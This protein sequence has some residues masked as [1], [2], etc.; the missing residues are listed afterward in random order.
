MTLQAIAFADL[1]TATGGANGTAFNSLGVLAAQAAPALDYDPVSLAVR[2]LLVRRAETNLLGFSD[3]FDQFGGNVAPN[4]TSVVANVGTAPDGTATADRLVPS[5]GSGSHTRFRSVASLTSGLVY[6]ASAVAKKES[7]YEGFFV[8]LVGTAFPAQPSVSVNLSTGALGAAINGASALIEPWGDGWYRLHCTATAG[9]TGSGTWRAEVRPLTGTATP[10]AGD[11]TSGALVW[12]TQFNAG[13][14]TGHIPCP[15]ASAV[16]RTADV[17][18]IG[19][20]RFA[21]FF[22]Q[23]EGTLFVQFRPMLLPPAAAPQPVISAG[24]GTLNNRVEVQHR[25]TGLGRAAVVTGGVSQADY[26]GAAITLNVSN[27]VALSFRDNDVGFS[28]NGGATVT[29]ATATIA[30][31]MT[32][33]GFGVNQTSSL[34]LDGWLQDVVFIPKATPAAELPALAARIAAWR[35]SNYRVW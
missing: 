27:T 9:A 5:T 29:D 6:T 13:G 16:A 7:S 25:D 4:D 18:T 28:V 35:A 10:Y 33:L 23:G 22:R 3:Q 24:D 15:T 32:S 20:T 12:G 17:V 31:V 11:G 26:S 8:S 21:Q 34:Q 14:P 19:G 1:F 2:G 30:T